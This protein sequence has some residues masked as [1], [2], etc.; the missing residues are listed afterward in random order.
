MRIVA[1]APAPGATVSEVA[2]GWRVFGWRRGYQMPRH[3]HVILHANLLGHCPVADMFTATG[4]EW[5]DQQDLV[6]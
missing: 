4:R 5:V 3:V 2:R 1:Q 6:L